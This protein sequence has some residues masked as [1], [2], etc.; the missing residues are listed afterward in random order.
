MRVSAKSDYALRALIE[1]ASRSDGKAVSAEELGKQQEI[2]HG[3]LQAIL[4]DLRRSGVVMSQRGQSGG[5][6]MAR[7][8]ESVSVADVIRAVDGPLASVRGTRSEE[9]SYDGTAEP[10]REVWI[11]LRASLRNVLESVTLADVARREL[12]ASV[13]LLAAEPDAWLPH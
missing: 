4:A 11:A 12:P 6:R 13:A 5:W 10:L 1:M 9:L 3:F 8:P 7:E 2:P